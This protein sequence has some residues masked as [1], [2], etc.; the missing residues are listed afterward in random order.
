MNII[1]EYTG[2]PL[3]PE[4]RASHFAWKTPTAPSTKLSGA[5]KDGKGQRNKGKDEEDGML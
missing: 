2:E 5:S 3:L 1:G 4:P